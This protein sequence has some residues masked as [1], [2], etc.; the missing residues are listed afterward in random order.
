MPEKNQIYTAE[1]TGL[2]SEGSGVC[3]IENM[4]VFVPETAVGDV[5]DV[6]IV[7]VL[8]SY[9]FG[10]VD[11]LITPSLDREIRE[12]VAYKKCGGCV[13]RHISYEAECCAKADT[14]W[15][16]FER[17]G[18][19]SPEYDEFIPC[20]TPDRYRNKAQYPLAVVDG[21]A[22]C[23]FYAPRSHRVVPIEDCPLQPEI[24]SSITADILEYINKKK[25]PVYD[26]TKGT[27]IMRHIY[28]RKG[29]YSNEIMV[30]LV[31]RKEMSRQLS[32]LCGRLTEKYPDIKSIVMN[33]NPT[34]TNVIL[35]EEC[36]TLWGSDTISDTMCSNKIEI[37]PLSFYQINT[38]QA[39][40]LYAKALEYAAPEGNE[41]IADLYCGAGTIGLSMAHR[42]K[43]IVGIEIIPEAVE[44]AKKNAAENNISNA[45]FYC[46]DAG[47]VF[48]QLHKNGCNPDIIV[49][50]PPRK[51]C[52]Q[53]SLDVILSA[54][55]RKIV[56]IS[57]NPATAARDA[58]YL[59]DN[60]YNVERVCGGDFFPGTK[61]VE[62]V[63]KMIRKTKTKG[64]LLND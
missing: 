62:C 3:R 38:P 1:I 42:A 45:E 64:E 37:S 51:G 21:K 46:G 7:K 19:L 48:E 2:T 25:L 20:D 16:A 24:F 55:P 29:A 54:A 12:C 10:I 35:G 5:A 11:K 50:D 57:C 9:C 44:N 47:E 52:S 4:A 8:S 15:S 27:G 59:S 43:K 34:R 61:H 36:V 26:E 56:M 41:V 28:L 18:G 33:I 31:V 22:V 30:C 32:A 13:Y 60:G 49:V 40:R 53:D 39:E 23:G 58:K 14:V 63:V 6:K 17:I